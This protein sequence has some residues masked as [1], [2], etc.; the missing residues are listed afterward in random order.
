M[1]GMTIPSFTDAP[2]LRTDADV[3]AR[4]TALVGSAH[5]ERQLWVMLV[6]GDNQQLPTVL[7]ISAIPRSPDRRGLHA[8]ERLLSGY[9]TNLTTERGPG[10]VIFTMERTGAHTILPLDREWSDAL[11]V[12]CKHQGVALRG[13]FLSTD[14]GVLRMH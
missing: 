7:P 3:L 9:R 13:V 5:A 11:R 4:V 2:A 12:A 8:L 6:D 14:D 1:A 10:S